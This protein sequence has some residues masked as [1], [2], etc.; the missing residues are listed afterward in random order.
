[1]FPQFRNHVLYVDNVRFLSLFH[2]VLKLHLKYFLNIFLLACLPA[3]ESLK[4]GGRR[5]HLEVLGV[6]GIKMD[7]QKK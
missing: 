1:M 5:G 2:I 7:I 3:K 4:G 6:D